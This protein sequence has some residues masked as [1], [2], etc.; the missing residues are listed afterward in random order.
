MAG[1]VDLSGTTFKEHRAE[2]VRDQWY[3]SPSFNFPRK[4]R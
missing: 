4:L 2:G 1:S 3:P